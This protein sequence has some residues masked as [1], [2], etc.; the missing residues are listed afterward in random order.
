MYARGIRE[1]FGTDSF[2]DP[3]TELVILKQH[4]SVDQFHDGFLSLLNLLNLP[5]QH[6]LSIFISNLKTEIGQ[7]LKLFKP[8]TLVEGY[9]LAR[10]RVAR[11]RKRYSSRGSV[12]SNSGQRISSKSLSQAELEDRRKNGLCFWCGSK[13][14]PGHKCSKSQLYQLIIEPVREQGSDMKRSSFEEFSDFFDQLD[15]V[16]PIPESLVLSLHAFQG[17]QG[18]NTM[19]FPTVIGNTEVVALVDSGSTHNFIDLKVAKRL[20]LVIES[21]STL[22]VMVSN[23]VRLSI[24]GICR[25][26]SWEAQGNKFTTDFLILSVKGFDL[27][28]N[29]QGTLPGSL[30]LVPSSQLSKCLSLVGNR[31]SHMLLASSDQTALVMQPSQ[32]PPELQGLLDEFIDIFQVPTS[33]PLPRLQ[34]HMIPLIDESKV[35]KV[36]PYR[37]PAVQKI[38][39]EKLI[40]EMLQAG[41]IRDCNSPFAFPVVMVKKKDAS[42]RLCVDYKQLNQLTIKDRLPIPVIE[43][44][45]DELGQ[46][47]FFS[48]LDLRLGY[49]QIRIWEPNVFKT[50]FKTHAGHYEFLVMPFG[51][52]NAPSSI[53][54]LMN[55]IF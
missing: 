4:G 8:Q 54:S 50:T 20:N 37:Y 31:P 13:Y 27:D 5:E 24:Q 55:S 43:E 19:R 36:R 17:L 48:K 6:A 11:N 26:V 29:L 46:A 33:L 23:G 25:A 14:S 7:Y 42:W 34:D 15:L 32:L 21:E 41:I 3:M 39:I 53:Q 30:Q 35:V 47:N 18:H 51:L 9:N 16:D 40:Q 10:Q 44:L 45:L 49:H 2:I 12:N 38:E 28:C 1:H 52:T 22:R